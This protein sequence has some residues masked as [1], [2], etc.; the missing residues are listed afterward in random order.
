MRK[1]N[2][3]LIGVATLIGF[4][5]LIAVF[6]PPG[7]T[8]SKSVVINTNEQ[9]VA[10][11]I[12]D[13]E[14]WKNWYPA[15]Q[16]K[17]ITAEISQKNDTSFAILTNENKKKISLVLS[18]SSP[19]NINIRVSEESGDTKTYGFVLS[20]NGAQQT[21]LTWNVNIQL[22][23]YPWRKLAGIFLDKVTGPHYEAALQN[24]KIV[25]EKTTH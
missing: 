17:D 4:L 6:L 5:C 12:D 7:I 15:F 10:R 19:Q 18:K 22:G 21:Q 14:N 16:N 25:A 9:Q 8:V 1:V 11:Q 24:L 2:F 20:P 13:F 23:W 3:F